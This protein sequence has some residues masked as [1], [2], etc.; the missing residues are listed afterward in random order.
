MKNEILNAIAWTLSFA[1]VLYALWLYYIDYFKPRQD[2]RNAAKNV[3]R[4]F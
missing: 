4:G 1:C 3:R 2:S